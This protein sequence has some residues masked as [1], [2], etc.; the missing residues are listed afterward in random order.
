[1]IENITLKLKY[2]LIIAQ[3]CQSLWIYIK[4]K[5][6]NV[7]I[8]QWVLQYKI[9]PCTKQN[10]ELMKNNASKNRNVLINK[11]KCKKSKEIR[12]KIKSKIA[13]KKIKNKNKLK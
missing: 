7:N 9:L 13:N 6:L 3:L 4:A 1:M 12:K 2:L 11:N 8:D 10:I 5:L